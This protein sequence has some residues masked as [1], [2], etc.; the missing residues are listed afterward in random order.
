MSSPETPAPAVTVAP[1]DVRYPALSRGFNQRWIARP[2]YVRM[3]TSPRGV[4]RALSE[5]V[6]QPAVDPARTR[7]TVRSG[8]HCYE[9]F[10]CGDDVRVILDVS[11][12]C[13]M[14]YDPDMEAWCVEPGA[15]NWHVYSHLF[16]LSGRTLP[17][18]SCYS[19][20]LGGH[21]T[22]GGY[23]LLSRQAGLTV[24]Y[25]YAVE[26]AVVTDRRTVELVVATRDSPDPDLRDLWWA[27]TGG[28]GG[29]F[30]VVTRF[31]FRD[32]PAPPRR[33]LVTARTWSW[34][35]FT[36]KHF[37]HLV[38]SYGEYFAAHQDP[39]TAAGRL[40]TL[41]TLTHS[42]QGTNNIGLVAQVNADGDDPGDE[43][44]AAMLGFLDTVDSDAIPTSGPMLSSVAE[45]GP[46]PDAWKPRLMPWLTATQA[47]NS[48]GENRCG[49]YKSAYLRRPFSGRQIQAMWDYLGN[50]HYT[51]YTN[52]EAVIQIDSYGSAINRPPRDTAVPQ[53]DSIL[54]MQYQVY[55][56]RPSDTDPGDAARHVAWIR[57]TYQ[58]TFADTGGVPIVGSRTDGCYINYPDV[59]LNDPE[60]NTSNQP[61][62]QLYYKDAYPRLQRAKARWDPLNIFRHQQS[63]EASS[64]PAG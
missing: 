32:P 41:L 10:V 28:G 50:T 49:K 11:P 62:S 48:S 2:E 53:R 61:W 43:G 27:H 25:L 59:D 22:G 5:A 47:L 6:N 54:K 60:W 57:D 51:D 37:T 17:A 18:G 20:G 64:D 1:A 52:P 29:N 39:A 14:H 19:V 38:S 26:V 21:I 13:G 12:M 58:A 55:W 23:G 33:V 8:G 24:D 31:W 15:T 34:Q 44:V 30:G 45:H 40:F 63:I 3:V 42:N 36:Q 7:V 4:V 46:I 56:R 9:D 16:P 35:G